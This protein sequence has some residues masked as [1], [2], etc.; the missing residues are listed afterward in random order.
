MYMSLTK[1]ER[2][3]N[4]TEDNHCEGTRMK[5]IRTEMNGVL[6]LTPEIFEDARGCF[7]ESFNQRIFNE[8][9]GTEH[10]FVQDNQSKSRKNVLRGL[11]YQVKRPQGKLVRVIAG[12]IDDVAVDLRKGSGSYGRYFSI[13][14][15]SSEHNSLWVPPGFAHGFLALSDYSEVLY[16]TTDYYAP[17]FERTIIWNDPDLSIPWKIRFPILSKK[18]ECGG[19]FGDAEPL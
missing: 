14:L 9:T 5:A 11:H 16:K 12:A 1:W 18:D 3:N 6:L 17:E 19:R 7:F 4:F 13:T 15:S 10:K 2:H 8:I